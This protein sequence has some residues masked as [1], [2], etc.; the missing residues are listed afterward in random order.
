M[1][2]QQKF[3]QG[4][5]ICHLF[6]IDLS[7]QASTS[8]IYC[9]IIHSYNHWLL[10]VLLLNLLQKNPCMYAYAYCIYS[11]NYTL[12]LYSDFKNAEVTACCVAAALTTAS[13]YKTQY[14]MYIIRMSTLGHHS[15]FSLYSQAHTY[16]HHLLNKIFMKPTKRYVVLIYQTQKIY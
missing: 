4:G 15:Q 10:Y 14:S 2:M 3:F 11:I 12:D 6:K 13:V 9:R 8:S 7:P 1:C 5:N 16:T